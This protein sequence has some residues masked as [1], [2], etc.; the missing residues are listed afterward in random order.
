MEINNIYNMDCNKGMNK[1]IK[2][3]QKVD[4]IVADPL[5]L[6]QKNHNFIQ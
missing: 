1:M 2:E 3:N 4:L 6:Y 5:M